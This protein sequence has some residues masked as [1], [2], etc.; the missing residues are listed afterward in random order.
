MRNAIISAISAGAGLIMLA[1]LRPGAAAEPLKVVVTIPPI[2]SLAEAVM[3]GQGAPVL[4]VKGASSEHSYSMRPSDARAL[5]EADIVVRV[6]E[7][8]ETFLNKPIAS[9][10][11]KAKVVT[12]VEDA[13]L[14]LLPPREGGDFEAHRHEHDEA[15]A[16]HDHDHGHGH[17]HPPGNAIIFRERRPGAPTDPHIWLDTANA[18]GIAMHLADVFGQAR[19]E[20]AEAFRAN[21]DKLRRKIH[22]LELEML[23]A[24]LPLRG[25]SFIVFHDAYRYF[26]AR[27]G[28]AASGSITVS[29]ERQPGAAQLQAIRAKIEVAQS[30]CVFSEPQFEPKL[31]ARLVEGTSAKTGVLDGLGAGLP[32]GPELYFT[33]MRKLAASLK[34]CLGS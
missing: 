19:P 11:G 30:T 2:H 32:E 10:A 1:S 12:L 3:E 31:V 7:G 16:G 23:N 24:V 17:A 22:A 33:M 20:Q 4:L 34:E 9:L 13:P 15:V 27:Y 8:L 28:L 29:P 5:N 18:A 6:S 21:A 26:E 25:K 14:S